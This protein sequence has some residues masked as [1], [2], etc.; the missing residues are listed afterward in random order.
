[1]KSKKEIKLNVAR[2]SFDNDLCQDILQKIVRSLIK[3]DDTE[4][5]N[6]LMPSLICCIVYSNDI[7]LLNEVICAG[8]NV[9]K[10]DYDFRTPL[11]IACKYGRV[12]IARILLWNVANVQAVCRFGMSPLF[13]AVQQKQDGICALL[14]SHD[15]ELQLSEDRAA[16]LLCWLAYENNIDFVYRLVVSGIDV[17]L[18]DYDDRSCLDVARDMKHTGLVN[19]ITSILK[20]EDKEREEQEKKWKRFT[21]N[22]RASAILPK[23]ARMGILH[24]SSVGHE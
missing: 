1:M 15:A 22:T 11:H 24:K 16:S 17:N 4:L 18:T 14:R 8:I 12:E 19:Y 20:N 9:T 2:E 21:K 7:Q 13:E 6:I 5:Q 3:S 23:W 10:G